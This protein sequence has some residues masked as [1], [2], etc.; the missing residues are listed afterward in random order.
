M[1][2][3]N[4]ILWSFFMCISGSI[5]AADY[6]SAGDTLW[7]WA[8]TGLHMRE[9]PDNN[10]RV[11]ETIVKGEMV[12][13]ME[14]I[15]HD[16]PYSL[17]VIKSEYRVNEDN[18]KVKSPNLV[19]RGYWAKVRYNG[20]VGYVFDQY[21]SKIPIFPSN[22]KQGEDTHVEGLKVRHKLIHQTGVNA[23]DVYDEKLVRYIFEDGSI[24]EI[25]GGSGHWEKQVLFAGGLSL[26]EGYLLYR[27]TFHVDFDELLEKRDD[28]L[29]FAIGDGVLTIYTIG[30]YVIFYETHVC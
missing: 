4:L 2:L 16:Y 5:D 29:K 14:S 1:K 19:L 28:Y 26:T 25:S 22:V 6:Y 7:V 3:Q 15:N 30:G 23:Y 9:K 12:V 11:F 20:K 24:V 21:L 8:Q 10:S 18:K 17:E 13:V 27:Q